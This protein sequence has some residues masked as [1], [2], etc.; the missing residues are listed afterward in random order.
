MLSAEVGGYYALIRVSDCR[1]IAVRD[2]HLE[3]RVLLYLP[4]GTLLAKFQVSNSQFY[5]QIVGYLVTS[6][7]S[8]YCRHMKM[9]WG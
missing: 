3:Y 4:D 7:Q 5:S 8:F 6:A 2:T 1:T 9:R